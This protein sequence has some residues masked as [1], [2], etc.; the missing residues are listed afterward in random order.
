[1]VKVLVGVFAVI[2]L[3]ATGVFAYGQ[4]TGGGDDGFEPVAGLSAPAEDGFVMDLEFTPQSLRAAVED[5]GVRCDGGWQ[6]D[7]NGAQV[8]AA[9]RGY[10]AV[11]AEPIE[12]VVDGYVSGP[13]LEEDPDQYVIATTDAALIVPADDTGW[14]YKVWDDCADCFGWGT[15]SSREIATDFSADELEE[16]VDSTVGRDWNEHNLGYSSCIYAGDSGGPLIAGVFEEPTDELLNELHSPSSTTIV[17][18]RA[19]LQFQKTDAWRFVTPATMRAC[20]LA[21]PCLV[22]IGDGDVWEFDPATPDEV[23][24]FFSERSSPA[25]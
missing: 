21:G 5:H 8:C 6:D 2:G 22:K 15:A 20:Q 1:M 24:E 19:A 13:P 16:V 9:E 11:L 25:S 10:Y 18:D 3:V 7:V 4:L 14:L 23:D 12:R 17:G